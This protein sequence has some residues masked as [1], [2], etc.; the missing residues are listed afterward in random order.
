MA[1]SLKLDSI[2]EEM[3]GDIIEGCSAKPKKTQH[4]TDPESVECFDCDDAKVYLP[5]GTWPKFLEK[6][7]KRKYPKT[8]VECT[9]Q[10][11][12]KETDPKKSRDQN[13]VFEEALE[14]LNSTGTVFLALHTGF[15][16]TSMGNYFT[17]YL[18][19]KT[20]VLC[21]LDEVRNQ[22]VDEFAEFSTAKVQNVKGSQQS[23]DPDADVYIMGILATNKRSR[24][25]LRHIGLVVIDESH[26]ATVT[27]FSKTLLKFQ[28]SKLIGLSATPTRPDGL[29]KLLE[30]YFG[31]SSN[32]V[33]RK[34]VKPFT[35]YKVLTPFVPKIEYILVKGQQSL[36]YAKAINSIAYCEERQQMVVDMIMERHPPRTKDRIMVLSDRNQECINIHQLL[37]DHGEVNPKLLIG[38]EKKTSTSESRYDYRV[39]VAGVK[40]GGVGFNDPTL[41]VLF[42]L[43]DCKDVT[44][45]EGRIRTLNCT[46]YVF[47]DDYR[48]F[49]NHWKLQAKW[50]LERG[51]EIKIINYR[52]ETLCEKDHEDEIVAKEKK[53]NTRIV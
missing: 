20:A 30:I 53:F 11:F 27:A 14:K 18:K 31:P 38:S 36:N 25:E 10:L 33:I 23:L 7:P 39:I 22:W 41:N 40:K 43:H 47:V 2:S 34:E 9:K 5:L 4:C 28:P 51:A 13:A 6:Q 26:I 21:H 16:K 37:I 19:L 1:Y 29:G 12:T 52:T 24:E 32:F 48:M 44:Q 46:I 50:F 35:V 45:Y 15:G 42:L 3:M 17:G 8:K 49:E